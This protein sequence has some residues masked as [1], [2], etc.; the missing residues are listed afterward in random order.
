[1]TAPVITTL[2]P[3]PIPSAD[4]PSSN[5]FLCDVDTAR[6]PG[7]INV[8]GTDLP[9]GTATVYRVNNDNSVSIVRGGASID[10]TTGGF[11]LTDTEAPFGVP[12]RYLMSFKPTTRATL[13][14]WLRN[15]SFENATAGKNW[16]AGT[17]RP[18]IITD[19]RFGAVEP[20]Y[21]SRLGVVGPYSG[22]ISNPPTAAQRTLMWSLA[23]D[24]ISWQ[25]NMPVRVT[26]Q[27]ALSPRRNSWVD[28]RD[29]P[30]PRTWGDTTYFAPNPWNTVLGYA[31]G[32]DVIDA[33]MYVGFVTSTG[34][35]VGTL[36]DLSFNLVEIHTESPTDIKFFDLQ[37]TTPS[38]MTPGGS[39]GLALF[40]DVDTESFGRTWRFDAIA[41]MDEMT[42]K[43]VINYFDGSSTIPPVP[44]LGYDSEIT[45]QSFAWDSGDATIAWMDGSAKAH[46]S[47]SVFTGATMIGA[48]A[49]GCMLQAPDSIEGLPLCEPVALS[50]PILPQY[51]QWLGLLSIESL[52]WGARRELLDVLGRNAPVSLSEARATPSTSFRF[53]TRTLN[54]RKQFLSILMTGRILL[55]RNPDPSYPET[56][57]YLSIG[58]VS[59]ER[60]AADHRE[61][62]RRW[63]VSAQVVDRPTVMIVG[64]QGQ[65]WQMVY[66][67]DQLWST[68]LTDYPDWLGVY[69]G[70]DDNPDLPGT[71][72]ENLEGVYAMG[73]YPTVRAAS[74]AWVPVP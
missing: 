51:F 20:L 3:F 74:G 55:L 44:G 24:R 6:Y 47:A 41:L 62:M 66:D 48:Y 63:V 71:P 57:W 30:A 14:N 56:D 17:G 27:V 7:V 1:M 12:V 42:T 43:Y 10:T 33:R 59:E 28:A 18:A 38:T 49:A 52:Q 23:D 53:M 67:N 40:Q 37:I 72:G 46:D 22:T 25:P 35:L 70:H 5:L 4:T 26:G 19:Q 9:D 15:P 29:K 31:T 8:V 60:I 68:V 21:G 34:A 45:G 61:P 39:Y 65:T 13:H 58:E 32:D 64:T 2:P 36:E 54:Q 16:T 50:D 73:R 69:M 11:V